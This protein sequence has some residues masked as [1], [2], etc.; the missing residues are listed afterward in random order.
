MPNAKAHAIIGT[1]SGSLVAFLCSNDLP[2]EARLTMTL[3]GALGGYAGGRTPDSLEPAVHAWHRSFFHS[4]AVG[5]GVLQTTVAPIKTWVDE[6][7]GKAAGV[8][9]RRV[10]LGPEHPD[11]AALWLQEFGLYFLCGL[12]IGVPVG[13]LS[14]LIVDAGTERGIPLVGR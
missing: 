13:Y 3:G 4:A 11:H 6:L 12:V 14:H 1:G 9:E 8:R 7:L 5:A 10:Q 2:P